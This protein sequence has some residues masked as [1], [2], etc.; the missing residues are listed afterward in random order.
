MIKGFDL[1]EVGPYVLALVG[2]AAAFVL[3]SS[4]TIRRQAV[5]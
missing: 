4:Q 5:G 3:L 2:F 1:I